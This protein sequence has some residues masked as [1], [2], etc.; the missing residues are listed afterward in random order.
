MIL[1]VIRAQR[2]VVILNTSLPTDSIGI[3]LADT[4]ADCFLHDDAC[5]GLVRAFAGVPT[6]VTPEDWRLPP[7]RDEISKL[8]PAQP[9]H[10]W[11][12][13][14]TSGTTGTPKGIERQHYSIVTELIG[15]CLELGL[16]RNT[17]FYIG[18]PLYYTG[19]L[20]LSLST[21]LAGGAVIL[22]DY[23][24]DSRFDE[25]WTDY[26]RVSSARPLSWAFFVPDQVRAFVRLAKAGQSAAKPASSI[27]IMGAS[28]S[29]TEK[30]T[31]RDTLGSEIVESWGNSESLGTIT[32]P[33]DLDSRPESI[34]RPFLTDRM[35]VVDEAGRPLPTGEIGRLAGDQE[36]G[37]FA[38]SNRPDDTDL[39]KRNELIISDDMGYEDA[40][41]YFYVLGRDQDAVLHEGKTVFIPGIESAFLR[42]GCVDEC[43]I[44]ATRRSADIT[45]IIVVFACPI[46]GRSREDVESAARQAAAPLPVSHVAFL[47]KIPRLGSGKTDRLDLRRRADAIVQ[48]L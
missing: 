9:E 24:D 10:L 40:D 29:G 1:G 18:R 16:T 19:G 38:Y 30:T 47:D 20:V 3:N 14:F 6:T 28:I 27:L 39:V 43:A 26:K 8:R 5:A 13:L 22:N 21:L 2:V 7:D 35:F 4:A 42:S 41:G 11:G 36:A 48:T 25:I 33:S 34:G 32:D 44:V 31:A 17:L 46:A 37:F 45:P 12:V 23:S 15:W